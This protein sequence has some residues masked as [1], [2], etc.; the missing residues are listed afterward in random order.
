MMFRVRRT[1]VWELQGGVQFRKA[2][3]QHRHENSA[4]MRMVF[5]FVKINSHR[6]CLGNFQKPNINICLNLKMEY[7]GNS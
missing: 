2:E 7:L 1:G 4:S 6:Q 5:V 3:Y